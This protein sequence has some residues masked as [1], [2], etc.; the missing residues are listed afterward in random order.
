MTEEAEATDAAPSLGLWLGVLAFVLAFGAAGYAWRG[1]FQALAMSP[2]DAAISAAER[3]QTPAPAQIAAMVQRLATKLQAEPNDP[4]GWAMLGRSYS[5]MGQY[6]Q[7]LAAFRKVVELQP[8]DAQAYADLADATGMAN[9]QKL[10]GPAQQLIQQALALDPN[11][12]KALGLAGTVAFDQGDAAGAAGYWQR[13]LAQVEPGTELAIQLKDAVDAARQRARLQPLAAAS[14]AP[15]ASATA[16]TAATTAA[17]SPSLPA[18]VG[19]GLRVRV[20]LSPALAAQA[21]PDEVVYI[22]ARAAPGNDAAP[23]M[24]LAIQ[25]R[26]VKDLPLDI[27]LDDSMAMSPAAKLSSQSQVVVGARISKSGNPLPQPGD[28]QGLSDAIASSGSKV[29][30]EIGAVVR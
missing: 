29:N 13:A 16:T 7:A 1:N 27:T 26:Q 4:V 24:P 25:R 3:A 8:K 15:A 22:F 14:S 9:G 12:A 28:L 6:P 21:R 5:V 30:V 19:P 20:T 11:N 17:T 2:G 23:K 10:D 18:V